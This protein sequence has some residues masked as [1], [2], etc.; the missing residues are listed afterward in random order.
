[1]T[2]VTKANIE[3]QLVAY[4]TLDEPFHDRPVPQVRAAI[5]AGANVISAAIGLGDAE[6]AEELE[7]LIEFTRQCIK[8]RACD[9]RDLASSIAAAMRD[10]VVAALSDETRGRLAAQLTDA[11]SKPTNLYD[12]T[13]DTITL[14]EVERIAF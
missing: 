10:D 4:L 14:D 8:V 2:T 11:L 9:R 6:D 13:D 1:M 12:R 7:Q 5:V 3:R